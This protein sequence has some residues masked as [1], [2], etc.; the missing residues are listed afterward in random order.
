MILMANAS[1]ATPQTDK[2]LV[3]LSA[4]KDLAER[5]NTGRV[6]GVRSF[7]TL[8]TTWKSPSEASVATVLLA[9]AQTLAGN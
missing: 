7:A 9:Q 6:A 1:E 4:A 5:S 2:I 3:V 8:R